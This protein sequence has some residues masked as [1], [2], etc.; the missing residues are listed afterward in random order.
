MG[1]V[2][3][4]V[5]RLLLDK[6]GFSKELNNADKD[7]KKFQSSSGNTFNAIKET[8][9]IAFTAI[10]TAIIAVGTA[11]LKAAADF[12][13]QQVAFEVLLGS[14]GKAQTL[15]EDIEQFAATTPFQMPGLIE[16]TKRL[17]A[18]GVAEGQVVEKMKNLGNAAMGNQEVLARLTDAYGKLK[19]KGK[20]SMEELNRFTE[21][22]VPI[23]Q[24]L[25]DQ[26]GVA[27]SELLDMVS[28]GK[29]SFADVD[30][31]L[32]NLTTGS[33]KFAGMIEKQSTT[34]GG[35]FSTLKDNIGLVAK[36]IGMVLA[37]AAKEALGGAIDFLD[38]NRSSIVAGFK[39]MPELAMETFR[40][41]GK[42][43]ETTFSW[44]TLGGLFVSLWKGM[45]K[46]MLK[47]AELAWKAIPKMAIL[48]LDV[49]TAPIQAQGE[50]MGDVFSSAWVRI[51]NAG[52]DAF[53]AIIIGP[54]ND[55]IEAVNFLSFGALDFKV[56]EPLE[57]DVIPQ[58][59][60]WGEVWDKNI[61]EAG[62]SIGE[63][64]NTVLNY[65][66][67]TVD[68]MT[69]MFSDIGD[70]YKDDVDAYLEAVDKIIQAKK[71][72]VEEEKQAKEEL[73]NDEVEIVRE[74]T[75][76]EIE[77]ERKRIDALLELYGTDEEQFIE[78][79]NR[80]A[81]EYKLLLG[82]EFDSAKWT[83][84]QIA[85]YKKKKE[86]EAAEYAK[87]K[88]QERIQ[89]IQLFTNSIM[90]TVGAYFD[91]QK[92]EIDANVEDEKKAEM[93]KAK[94]AR[95]QF[96]FNKVATLVQIGIS[97]AEA[98]MKAFAMLGPIG[99]AIASG[100]I[101]ALAAAQAGFVI[102]Q[103]PPPL[104]AYDRGGVVGGMEGVDKNLAYVSKGEFIV[105]KRDAAK[106]MGVLEN[107]NSGGSG[108]SVSMAPTT[109]NI[110][111]SD[112]RIIG[113]AD[114]EYITEQSRLGGIIIHPRAIKAIV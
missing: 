81:E 32:T 68:N 87:K 51:K 38:K 104:P 80:K 84:D 3:D 57:K 69:S 14:A 67:D 23:V 71:K 9:M 56:F 74:K 76:E 46:G 44:D 58:I 70:L 40:T 29:V 97:T 82:D 21:A 105:N 8:A 64:V 11:S 72:Q 98:I 5:A 88:L 31:A 43:I 22:G 75:K 61:K 34:L 55:M 27:T 86:D 17:L 53:N 96:N 95:D 18:F 106:N 90:G 16:G 102:A 13:K 91:M 110:M 36:D 12:E 60:T 49:I 33:G 30:K 41:I 50:F 15:L 79:I 100:V 10:S 24:A 78:S 109:I 89:L 6:K 37:P 62:E 20:A 2:G 1:L 54:I 112:E 99:G 59:R 28:K 94:L 52:I 47:Q 7:A 45:W 48:A 4:L 26:Y 35:L 107:I 108:I 103:K 63:L 101:G 92:A 77:L 19:A 42:I 114:L 39:A 73:S 66:G 111:T 85:A 25:A 113:S 83:A 65:A 93:E